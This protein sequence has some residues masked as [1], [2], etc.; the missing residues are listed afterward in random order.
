M[1]S[2]TNIEKCYK[3]MYNMSQKQ[4]SVSMADPPDEIMWHPAFC[5]AAG[6]E[7][8]ENITDLEFIPEYNL[9]KEPIRIDLLILK[10]HAGAIKNEIGH[11]MRKYNII[12]YKSPMDG[13]SIDDFAKTLGYAL[14]Y[15]GYGERVDQIPMQELTVSMFRSVHPRELFAEL[16][17]EGHEIE[18]K[19][20][21]IYYVTNNLPFPA[22]IVVTSELN[23]ELHSSLRILTFDAKME[24]VTRFLEQAKRKKTPGEQENIDAVLQA[25]VAA[26]V[27]LYENVRRNSGM[28]QALRELMKD[29]ID[30]EIN[31]AVSEATDK[32][33]TETMVTSIRRV[34]KNF[35]CSV[36][37]AMDAL[38]IPPQKRAMYLSKL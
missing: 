13:M 6:L 11:I 7:L 18:E 32:T 19:Y 4:G 16:K 37:E 29:E 1:K 15:K 9:S 25:S 14:L 17:R 31:L 36:E 23:P 28:C 5:A 34:M 12:E 26:N 38:E 22:Q 20:S 3:E 24:D 2:K 33:E 8:Q 35:K 30:K 27:E 21:G 10:D